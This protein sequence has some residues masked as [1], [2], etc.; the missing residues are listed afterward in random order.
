[1]Q[2]VPYGICRLH[3]MS[4][5]VTGYVVVSPY[6]ASVQ[7]LN[8]GDN[9][10]LEIVPPRP[11]HVMNELA[12][13]ALDEMPRSLRLEMGEE[14]FLL[15][16]E[17]CRN[18]RPVVMTIESITLAAP[19][20]GMERLR[21]RLAEWLD[22]ERSGVPRSP[23]KCRL[24][25]GRLEKTG[26]STVGTPNDARTFCYSCREH[27]AQEAEYSPESKRWRDLRG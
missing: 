5:S 27:P 15:V 1:M 19:R 9:S 2:N 3:S 10:S 7:W 17:L 21:D 24:C 6:Y 22:A 13:I 14:T 23:F 4:D 11:L 18:D 16:A 26:V 20:F 8:S 25:G 12:V